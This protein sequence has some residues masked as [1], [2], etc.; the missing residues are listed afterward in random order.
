[1][2]RRQSG[3]SVKLTPT[4]VAA[5][6]ERLFAI[7]GE[8]ASLRGGVAAGRIALSTA[9]EHQRRLVNES[10]ALAAAISILSPRA[11][12]AAR[13]LRELEAS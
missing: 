4:L 12:L 13:L 5:L 8:L 7:P 3:T 6:R 1:M 9:R 10:R 11:P 2:T